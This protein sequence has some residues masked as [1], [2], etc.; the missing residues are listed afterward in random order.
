ERVPPGRGGA[1]AVAGVLEIEGDERGDRALVLDH[2]DVGGRRA[3]YGPVVV[4]CVPNVTVSGAVGSVESGTGC[5]SPEPFEH[6]PGASA[7]GS[8]TSV[9]TPMPTAVRLMSAPVK[10]SRY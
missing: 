10:L 5:Q 6:S 1:N 8:P 3:H 7:R 9:T 2:Q 4:G